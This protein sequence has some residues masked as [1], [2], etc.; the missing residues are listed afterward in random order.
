MAKSRTR[1]RRK[2]AEPAR[3]LREIRKLGASLEGA[4]SAH[5]ESV[6]ML[7]RELRRVGDLGDVKRQLD[8][9]ILE[10][11]RDL[12]EKLRQ[13]SPGAPPPP[14]F[15]WAVLMEIIALLLK[16]VAKLWALQQMR[17]PELPPRLPRPIPTA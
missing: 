12:L 5:L 10:E 14:E 1:G 6:L 16:M 11:L 13:R 8:K 3:I 7:L 17:P 2:S 9:S 15:Q 4:E